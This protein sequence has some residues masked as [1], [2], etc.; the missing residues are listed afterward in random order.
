M[1]LETEYRPFDIALSL[2][3]AFALGCGEPPGQADCHEDTTP[4]TCTSGHLL[5]GA[6]CVPEACGVGTWGDLSVDAGTVYVDIAAE[7]GGDGSAEAP[8]RSVQ[9]GVDLAGSQGGGLVA[10]A[11]GT[12]PEEVQLLTDHAGVHLAGRCSELVTLD[13]SALGNDA[14]GIYV[15]T[16]YAQVTISSLRVLGAGY[17]GIAFQSGVGMLED[18]VIEGTGQA[19]LAV[20][21]QSG[22]LANTVEAVDCVWSNCSQLGVATFGTATTL[23]LRGCSILDTEVG[24]LMVAALGVHATNGSTVVMESCEVVRSE[25]VGVVVGDEGTTLTLLDS[26]VRDTIMNV[27]FASGAGVQVQEG[28]TLIAEDSELIGNEVYGLLVRDE[29]ST[30]TLRSCAI[31]DTQPD[32]WGV[33]GYGVGVYHGSTLELDGGVI[34]ES[35]VGILAAHEGTIVVIDGLSLTRNRPA[36]GEQGMTSVG[37]AAQEGATISIESLRAHRNEGPA[38]QSIGED[39]RVRCDH[40]ALTENRF[41]G[42]VTAYEGTLELHGSTISGNRESVDL[43][44]GVGIYAAGP[45]GWQ[46]PQLR[47]SDSIVTDHEVAGFWLADPGSYVLTGNDISGGAGIPHGPTTRCGDGIYARDLDAWD[48]Q[49]GLFLSGNTL[50]QNNGTGLFLDD[51]SAQV[52]GNTWED[53]GLDLLVQGDA[54]EDSHDSFGEAPQRDI[55]PEWYQPS[56]RLAYTLGFHLAQVEARVPPPPGRLSHPEQPQLPSA[57]PAPLPAFELRMR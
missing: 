12:Y 40:C 13:S 26:S 43:G 15:E 46:G 51:A 47:V 39:T 5:D 29:D 30:A 20:S 41:A 18:L 6:S 44:G 21:Q 10:V 27:D 35:S 28:G 55:C 53:N 2:C 52:E 38:L 37:I 31:T 36:W 3:A 8:L 33:Y 1:I 24:G 17:I 42:A 25:E 45:R 4:P 54:C 7:D 23:T 56:C 57:A 9:A 14:V 48:G 16:R 19:G 49:D 11:A 34:S 50:H 32:P 22:G